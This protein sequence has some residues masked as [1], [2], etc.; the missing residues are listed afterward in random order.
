MNFYPLAGKLIPLFWLTAIALIALGLYWGFFKT[1]DVLND[2]KQYYRIIFV[3]VASAWMA[4]WLYAMMVAWA[5][6]GLIFNTRLS[7]M[8]A[9]APAP[10][11]DRGYRLP[12]V[13]RRENR[14]YTSKGEETDRHRQQPS[15]RSTSLQESRKPTSRAEEGWKRTQHPHEERTTIL[16][17]WVRGD[18]LSQSTPRQDRRTDNEDR[19]EMKIDR[20]S[21]CH[22]EQWGSHNLSHEQL[23]KRDQTNALPWQTVKWSRQVTRATPQQWSTKEKAQWQIN[24]A[25]IN[26]RGSLLTRGRLDGWLSLNQWKT[27]PIPECESNS[28]Q[29]SKQSPVEYAEHALGPI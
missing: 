2:Q 13:R 7:Y 14:T 17:L 16:A 23:K 22:D 4:M 21:T 1:A 9:S 15:T 25:T 27:H 6:I 10:R 24:R 20:T 11:T 26:E 5:M 29:R 8:M 18:W 12:N 28:R 19:Q 3:H